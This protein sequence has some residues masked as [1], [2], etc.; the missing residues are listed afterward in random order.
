MSFLSLQGAPA[1][2]EFRL[3]KLQQQL[4][5]IIPDIDAVSAS[6]WHFIK[7]ECELD[8][9]EL[10]HLNSILD[11]GP[12]RHEMDVS[13]EHFLVVPRP[14]TISPWSSKATDIAHHC[15]LEKVLRIERGVVW[16][17]CLK[18]HRLLDDNEKESI[19]LLIHDRMVET[20]FDS[21]QQAELL[22]D[23]HTPA[24]MRCVDIIKHGK[25]ALIRANL[26]WGL[27]LSEDEI[28]YLVDSFSTL[29]RNPTDVEL[30]MFAQVN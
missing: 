4:S 11:Y 15:D 19:S 28:D 2:S 22:F 25:Q 13:G 14:G 18:Q 20:V 5:E 17:I 1:I 9:Q 21:M 8:E 10:E 26:E 30:M 29:G 27:A 7:S 24:S 3:N 16:H 12:T 23:E 6:Y